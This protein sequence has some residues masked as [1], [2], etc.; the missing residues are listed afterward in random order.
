MVRQARRET[1][2]R[3][4]TPGR[5]QAGGGGGAGEREEGGLAFGQDGGPEPH[6]GRDQGDEGGPTPPYTGT[7]GRVDEN[8]NAPHNVLSP[9]PD[10]H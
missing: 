10:T 3:S 8:L 5:L 4:G 1:A 2:G 6:K 7:S 9:N